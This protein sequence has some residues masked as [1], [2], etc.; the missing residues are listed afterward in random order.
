M[1]KFLQSSF[2]IFAALWLSSCNNAE[3]KKQQE[4]A[5]YYSNA[6]TPYTEAI[7]NDSTDASLY[8][9]RSL[10]LSQ[11]R[12]DS[13]AIKDIKKAISLDPL[14]AAYHSFE[15]E[16]YNYIDD[17]DKALKAYNKAA[18]IDPKDLRIQINII[19]TMLFDDQ[20]A[21]A[22]A[23]INHLIKLIPDYPDAHYWDAMA[24]LL[25][26]DTVKSINILEHT[27]KLDP[28]FY[29]ASL[30][31]SDLY[32]SQKNNN[33]FDQYLYT[34]SLDTNDIYPLYQIGN[35]Y[36]INQ[37]TK[38]AK[39]SFL[40]S[41]EYNAEYTP[42]Y[43]AIGKILL[44]EDSIEKSKRTFLIASKTAPE[45]DEI[46]TYLGQIYEKLKNVD[47]AKLNYANALSINKK[48]A[49]AKEGLARLK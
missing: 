25:E 43:I 1:N 31:L 30:K 2:Y 8:Y 18:E 7:I 45:N 27:L 13:L 12:K 4:E 22:K 38:K 26:K 36:L 35:Y 21:T 10:A 37:D 34:Y 46:Y 23:K 48:N 9:K 11:I 28:Y 44:D 5:I 33:A 42:A 17:Y 24:H 32:A 39:A 3:E 16:L 49:T 20:I 41:L 19:K 40:K 6:I 14:N 29:E 15:G 47:S